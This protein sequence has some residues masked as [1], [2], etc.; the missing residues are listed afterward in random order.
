M[1]LRVHNGILLKPLKQCST[2][3]I[4]LRFQGVLLL[5]G[6]CDIFA[7]RITLN[8]A[9]SPFNK[10]NYFLIFRNMSGMGVI[11]AYCNTILKDSGNQYL[12]IYNKKK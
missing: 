10:N 6:H 11:I 1:P 7:R 12:Q 8:Y 5:I 9:F 2:F 4:R 3:L